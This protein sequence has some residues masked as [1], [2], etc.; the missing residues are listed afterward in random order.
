MELKVISYCSTYHVHYGEDVRFH[1]ALRFV[2][3]VHHPV[4]NHHRLHS[5]RAHLQRHFPT[6]PAITRTCSTLVVKGTGRF[7]HVGV[8]FVFFVWRFLNE[9]FSNGLVR[10]IINFSR[11]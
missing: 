3:F 5:P 6:Y 10:K 9:W 11:N 8:P 4:H 7:R 1:N 2:E